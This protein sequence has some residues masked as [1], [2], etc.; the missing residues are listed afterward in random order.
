[1]GIL[2]P[3]KLLPLVG[4]EV[5]VRFPWTH[6][7][8]QCLCTYNV[9][10]LEP[11][12]LLAVALGIIQKRFRN[13]FGTNSVDGFIE[14]LF[15]PRQWCYEF[16]AWWSTDTWWWIGWFFTIAGHESWVGSEKHLRMPISHQEAAPTIEHLKWYDN[17]L[18]HVGLTG[19]F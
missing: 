9:L 6:C 5:L 16:V 11:S 8:V 15:F 19:R 1:M 3:S 13:S 10:K 2:P 14:V 17:V 7:R 18:S 4:K 12:L